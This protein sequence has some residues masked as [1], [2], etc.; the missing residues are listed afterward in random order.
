MHDTAYK[1]AGKFLEL[2]WKPSNRVIVE[3]GS[4]SING[5]IRDHQP[6]G[7]KYIGV[8]MEAGPC[9]DVVLTDPLKLP[10]ADREVDCTISSSTFEHVGFFWE[11]FLELCRITKPGGYIYINAPSNGEFHRYPADYWRFYP[12]AGLGLAEWANHS[13]IDVTLVE[14]FVANRISDHWNDFVAVFQRGKATPRGESEFLCKSFACRNIY[15]FNYRQLEGFDART[16]D[17]QLLAEGNASKE[18]AQGLIE[19]ISTLKRQLDDIGQQRFLADRLADLEREMIAV[20]QANRQN[21]IAKS[22]EFADRLTVQAN[23]HL[24]KVDGLIREISALKANLADARKSIQSLETA[25]LNSDSK[26][27]SMYQAAAISK[28]HI[29]SLRREAAEKSTK[30][31]ADMTSLERQY[32]AREGELSDEIAE[33]NRVLS[34]IKSSI[35][36]RTM[37]VFRRS[38]LRFTVRQ[39]AR[40]GSTTAGASSAA[41]LISPKQSARVANDLPAT[42]LIQYIHSRGIWRN[43]IGPR[44]ANDLSELL[45]EHGSRFVRSAYLTLVRRDPDDPGLQFYLS[46]L[47]DGSQKIQI[48]SEMSQSDEARA[49]GTTLPGLREAIS[50]YR[51]T[52]VPVLGAVIRFI[53]R[54]EGDFPSDVRLRAIEQRLHESVDLEQRIA[55]LETWDSRIPDASLKRNG[56][57]NWRE[58]NAIRR[59][60]DVLRWGGDLPG[61]K[62]EAASGND[63]DGIETG[64]KPGDREKFGSKRMALRQLLRLHGVEFLE[65]AYDMLLRRLPDESGTRFYLPRL[66]DGTPKIQILGE[67]VNSEEARGIGATVPGL[68]SAI[69]WYRFSKTPVIGAVIGF[70]SAQEENTVPASRLRA[71]EQWLHSSSLHVEA[72]ICRLE[73]SNKRKNNQIANRGINR[74]GTGVHRDEDS[75]RRLDTQPD[76]YALIRDS[77]LFDP[78]WYREQSP[79]IDAHVDAIA[80]FLENDGSPDR[81]PSADFDS[82]WYL[83]R[84]PD[85][86]KSGVIPLVHFLLYGERE[87]RFPTPEAEHFALPKSFP[88]TASEIRC[89]KLPNITGEVA[90]FVTHS[91][92]GNIKPHVV[93]YLTSLKRHG[94]DIILVVAADHLVDTIAPN[95]VA[96]VSGLFVRQNE[97]YD[98]AAWAHALQLHPALFASPI[99]YLLNDSVFGPINDEKFAALLERIRRSKADVIGLTESYEH[100]WHL[101]S[102]FLAFK[103]KAL[104]SVALHRFINSITVLRDKDAVIRSYEIMLASHLRERGLKVETLFESAKIVA[105]E[106]RQ[107]S[108]V[109]PLEGVNFCGFSVHKSD[110]ASRHGSGNRQDRMAAHSEGG[111]IRCR[112]CG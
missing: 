28:R 70:L 32:Q 97:G 8:D 7:S 30:F 6:P 29:D 67:I 4:N 59:I 94:I 71:I 92:D 86:R 98:F 108:D 73:L 76:S 9:V 82:R 102:Y 34:E 16:Q 105:Q 15:R 77:G 58:L 27:E 65:A 62:V 61:E 38:G 50:R 85:L 74:K 13:G 87:G 78:I 100:N 24:A 49:L 12:D 60:A 2:Y 109:V 52:R 84:Y 35:T 56:T 93:H 41:G 111:G 37:A 10:F 45:R 107:N 21:F 101:Q 106:E 112:A 14:S 80:H 51:R 69:R 18:K 110:G 90:V 39:T 1:I 26:I 55:E 89:L 42:D 43:R 48:L 54:E 66:I 99:L 44:P 40:Q 63:S 3:L 103:P 17:M 20:L 36:W 68:V 95:V 91:P 46:R 83:S 22:L 25:A 79:A 31:A 75:L 5:S 19:Q 64:E 23:E 81:S 72:R 57:G 104:S 47:I 53:T 88:V 96:F 11:L 33:L